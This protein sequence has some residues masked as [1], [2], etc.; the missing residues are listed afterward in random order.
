[1]SLFSN[2]NHRRARTFRSQLPP[3]VISKI[4]QSLKETLHLLETGQ[5]TEHSSGNMIQLPLG[6]TNSPLKLPS[7]PPYQRPPIFGCPARQDKDSL[8]SPP[9]KKQKRL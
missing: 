9:P 3:L 1:M 4:T 2:L 7:P 5:C 6:S 8:L